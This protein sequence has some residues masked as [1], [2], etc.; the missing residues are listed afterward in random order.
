M[1]A[2]TELLHSRTRVRPR[3]ALM[4]MEGFPTSRISGWENAEIRVL[5]SPALGARFVQYKIDI[6]PGSGA[7]HE[8][9]NSVESFIYVMSG[10]LNLKLDQNS[11]LLAAGGFAFAPRASSFSID[12]KAASSIL[13]LRKSYES[14]PGIATPKPIV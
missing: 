5:A 9:D 6:Q 10:S 1:R 14:A 4:P 12:A 8:A 2:I 13:L 3:Y 7:K 11:S